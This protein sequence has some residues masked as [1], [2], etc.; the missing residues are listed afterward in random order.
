MKLIKE[1][2]NECWVDWQR[3]WHP[4]DRK[5]EEV[6]DAI[7]GYNMSTPNGLT[8]LNE[9]VRRT[10]ARIYLEAGV[11]V[12][13]SLLAAAIYNHKTQ[14]VGL[15]DLS[16]NPQERRLKEAI[17]LF[18]KNAVVY[19]ISFQDFFVQAKGHIKDRAVDVYYY[20]ADHSYKATID[21]LEMAQPYLSDDC[22]ILVDDINMEQVRA[23][24]D[25]FVETSEWTEIFTI[26][27]R[28]GADDA[29][30]WYNGT[31]IL[32]RDA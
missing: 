14:C 24:V 8:F 2:L 10:E 26:E 1:I 7:P 16:H 15:E 22:Y 25:T 17:Q 4:I 32:R 29:H 20:D 27:G 28:K 13:H 23:A 18:P 30:P 5:I 11:W 19:G 6:Y 21:G 31:A 12:G 9:L 3:D